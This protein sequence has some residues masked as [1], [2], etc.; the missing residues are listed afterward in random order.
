MS[1]QLD[2]Y[3]WN[4][5]NFDFVCILDV[6]LMYTFGD[7]RHGKLGLGMENFTN[8]FFPTLCCNFLRFT[9]QLVRVS[10]FLL[11]IFIF[12]DLKLLLFHKNTC[13]YI[14]MSIS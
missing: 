2:L 11:H 13:F 8:Q 6:G 7:G 10:H 4:S 1:L 12:L 5:S 14:C 3:K 9:V